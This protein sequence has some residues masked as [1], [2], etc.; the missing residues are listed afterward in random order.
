M[1]HRFAMLALAAS[2]T[3]A[4]MTVP[5]QGTMADVEVS[6][7]CDARPACFASL[8]AAVAAVEG[9]D[10][11]AP[12]R[13]RIGPGD[14]NERVVIT[15]SN[16]ALVGAGREATRLHHDLV[17][18][19]AGPLHRDGWGTAGSATLTIAGEDVT[20]T[21]LTIENDFD[22]LANDALPGGDPRKIGNSQALAVLLDETSDR[23]LMR[24]VALLGYQD[25]LFAHGGRA[26]I[27]DSLIAGNVDFIFGDGQLL[28]ED[29]EIRSRPRSGVDDDGWQ[30]YIAAP[31]TQLDQPVGI[32]FSNCRLTREAGVP[33]AS[34]ALA[35]PWHPT[36]TFADGRYADPR[37]VG[38]AVFADCFMDAHIAPAHWT[39][40]AGTAR[41]GTK[42]DIFRPQDSR[43]WETGS[44]GPGSVYQD[45]GIG[46][47]PPLSVAEMR[48]SVIR[49]WAED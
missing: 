9:M 42:T 29:S 27:R 41:D 36:T 39:S 11:N 20:I 30:S 10:A 22:Y 32:L 43:F 44:T 16:L 14:F 25:T 7:A 40:M 6:K 33:D 13:I 12:A 49:G 4:C 46:W 23:V 37:A 24:D 5:E 38:M 31:S 3:S 21:G 18:E 48:A 35:R 2:A 26:V 47:R 17:A 19:D 28:I 34:V 45:I 1:I 8:G 15:R